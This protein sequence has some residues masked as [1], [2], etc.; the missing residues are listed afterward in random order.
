MCLEPM[1]KATKYK[2][3]WRERS[4]RRWT[5]KIWWTSVH[6]EQIYK[7]SCWPTL[8]QQCVF[9]VCQCIWV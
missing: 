4:F 8:S 7:R 9:G 3:R 5:K 1:K 6:H 2:R